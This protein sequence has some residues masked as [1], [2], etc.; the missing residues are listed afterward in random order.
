MS[1]NRAVVL[2]HD[3]DPDLGYRNIGTLVPELQNRGYELDVHSFDYGHAEA[4]PEL[5]G[6][7]MVVVM[8]S[9]DAAYDDVPWIGPE[10]A[11]LQD[12]I[13]LDVPI[14]GI[15][16]GGQLLAQVLGGTVAKSKFPEYGFTAITTDT[17]GPGPWMEFHGDT[18]LAPDTATVIAR[19][20]AGQQAFVQGR[21]LGLQ[22][23]PEIDVDVFESWADAWV[24][25]GIEQD[26]ELVAV[27]RADLKAGESDARARCSDLLD[28]W[29]GRTKRN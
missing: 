6:A 13:D 17:I 12:A 23:H 8:G 15:C 18:F 7:A 20:D 11:Y 2:V 22:F 21:H 3:R 1:K 4:P 19:N 16:F 10:S 25:D 5:D 29:I 27:I 9:P 14:L 24:R 26:A 28:T